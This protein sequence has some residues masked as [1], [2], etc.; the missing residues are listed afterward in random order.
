MTLYSSFRDEDYEILWALL[1]FDYKSVSTP[2]VGLFIPYIAV[3]LVTIILAADN[4]L[5]EY[6]K[7]YP[8]LYL[9]IKKTHSIC[10]ICD[11]Q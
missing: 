2:L 10:M 6:L 5:S 7:W 3:V 1:H 4:K 11:Q 9:N 8:I